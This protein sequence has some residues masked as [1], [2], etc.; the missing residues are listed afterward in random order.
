MVCSTKKT[1]V[2]MNPLLGIYNYL[3]GKLTPSF[4]LASCRA[5][6]IAFSTSAPDAACSFAIGTAITIPL[7]DPRDKLASESFKQ[8]QN[9]GTN[10]SLKNAT[11]FKETINR[12]KLQFLSEDLL[13]IPCHRGKWQK[14]SKP[15][16]DCK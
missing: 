15:G 10:L 1:P 9:I 8:H 2:I 7:V 6:W 3:L 16:I 5:Y 4:Y 13:I 12:Y 11:N 14:Q